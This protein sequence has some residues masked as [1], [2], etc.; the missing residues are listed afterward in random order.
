MLWS[1]AL[2]G[3]HKPRESGWERRAMPGDVIAVRPMDHHLKWTPVERAQFLIVTLDDFEEGQLEGLV[4]PRWDTDSYQLIPDSDLKKLKPGEVVHLFPALYHNKR[5][6][7]VPLDDLRDLGVDI[8]SMLDPA[9][10]YTPEIN[11]LP[12]R[13]VYDKHKDRYALRTDGFNLIQ[14]VIV[15]RPL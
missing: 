12:M 2:F 7:H 1:A 8:D 14:P 4:E 15:G 5:R 11:P 13:R 3:H 10:R 6:F 9:W